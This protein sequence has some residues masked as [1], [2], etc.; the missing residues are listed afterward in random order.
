M[1]NEDVT[2]P[3]FGA[4]EK[5]EPFLVVKP[6]NLPSGHGEPL[7]SDVCHRLE[8]MSVRHV[9]FRTATSPSPA[10]RGPSAGGRCIQWTCEDTKR[11]AQ[12]PKNYFFCVNGENSPCFP[13]VIHTRVLST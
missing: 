6:L 1:M 10:E 8:P 7:L 12:L 13:G 11:A 4:D 5:A 3:L 2:I 9:L